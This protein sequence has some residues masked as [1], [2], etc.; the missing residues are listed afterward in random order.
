M[1][2]S[3]IILDFTS[4]LDVTLIIIF[5][6][7]LFSHIDKEEN[8]ARTDDKI[9]KLDIAI[10]EAKVSQ[11]EAQELSDKLE[12]EIRLVTDASE[13]NGKNI[14]GML[15]FNRNHNLKILLDMKNVGWTIRIIRNEEIIAYLQG[16]EDMTDEILGVMEK[17]GYDR[18]DPVLCD[19]VYDGSVGGT[20]AAY[21]AIMNG[22]DGVKKEYKYFYISETNMSIGS[23]LI[24][25][26]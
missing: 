25:E 2:K 15:D 21:K 26:E 11:D 10:E 4:L 1:R 22:L 14:S 18:E 5:F 16:K 3:D 8:K 19:F 9:H 7:V 12:E 17:S 24:L 13:R 20:R 23:E 6:F